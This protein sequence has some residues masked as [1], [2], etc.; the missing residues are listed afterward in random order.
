MDE[1]LQVVVLDQVKLEQPLFLILF[2]FFRRPGNCDGHSGAEIGVAVGT[3][4]DKHR[5][6]VIGQ[7]VSVFIGLAPGG[8]NYAFQVVGHGKGDK[9]SVGTRK[10]L[11]SQR[12][13]KLAPEKLF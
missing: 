10:L 8:K 1:F 5:D 12:G 7:Q 2:D 9:V 6:R 3:V 4:I 13:K 11:S